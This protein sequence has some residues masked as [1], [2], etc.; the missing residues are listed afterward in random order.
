MKSMIIALGS[1]AVAGLLLATPALA[2]PAGYV[3]GNYVHAQSDPG[4]VDADGWAVDGSVALDTGSALGVAL[5][6]NV[7]DDDASDSNWGLGG[8]VFTRLGNGLAGGFAK[9]QDAGKNA[10]AWAVGAEGQYNFTGFTAGA[11]ATWLNPDSSSFYDDAWGIDGQAK[12]YAT[13]NLRLS[14]NV[15]YG[16]FNGKAALPDD[17]EWTVGVGA[18]W[19]L[20]SLPISI[21]GD[22]AHVEFDKA[23]FS[24]DAVR[25]GGRFTWGGTLKDRNDRGADLHSISTLGSRFGF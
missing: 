15:G 13:D 22:Y 6:A 1:V 21:V 16:K 8:H 5:N 9:Y 3:G 4:N 7:G 11:A 12:I 14:G 24:S 17:H 2:A 19:Q 20:A 18:E 10:Q 25:V 23:N